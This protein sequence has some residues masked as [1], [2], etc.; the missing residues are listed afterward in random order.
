MHT[1]DLSLSSTHRLHNNQLCHWVKTATQRKITV[2]PM[3]IE[4]LLRWDKKII[5]SKNNTARLGSNWPFSMSLYSWSIKESN[6]SLCWAGSSSASQAWTHWLKELELYRKKI[7]LKRENSL[8]YRVRLES[9]SERREESVY[10]VPMP[11]PLV[12]TRANRE[13]KPSGTNHCNTTV[14]SLIIAGKILPVI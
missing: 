2:T 3:T 8:R 4:N 13:R 11:C 9:S 10:L 6:C 12:P 14:L 1:P 5:Y 7:E